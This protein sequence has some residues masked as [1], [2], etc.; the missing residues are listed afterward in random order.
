MERPPTSLNGGLSLVRIDAVTNDARMPLL[1][2]IGIG[3]A[4]LTLAAILIALLSGYFTSHDQGAVNGSVAAVGTKLPDQ[5]NGLLTAGQPR[6]RYNSDPPTSGP[7][8][9]VAITGE[10]EA[11]SDDQIL[12]ALAAG[13]VVVLYGSKQPPPGLTKL[14]APLTAPFTPAL[15]AAGQAVI[16]GHEPHLQGV[17]ALAW[18]RIL[19]Q[20]K[21]DGTTLTEFVDRWLGFGAGA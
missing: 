2:R 9:R 12:T 17:V 16:L 19:R 11:F 15:A 18:S 14:L 10:Y 7:H 3:V 5:G 1:E 21:P 13:D 8:A 4:A 20:R 6:P